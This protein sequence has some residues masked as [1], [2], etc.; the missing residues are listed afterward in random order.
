MSFPPSLF[1]FPH[2]SP[3]LPSLLQMV[4]YFGPDAGATREAPTSQAQQE[5]LTQG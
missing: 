1:L 5:I 3:G 2:L 4:P